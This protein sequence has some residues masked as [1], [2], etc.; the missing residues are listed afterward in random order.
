MVLILKSSPCIA[1]GYVFLMLLDA[2]TQK[3]EGDKSNI[4]KMLGYLQFVIVTSCSHPILVCVGHVWK[5]LLWFP[6]KCQET[7]HQKFQVC[8]I[9]HFYLI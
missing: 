4:V 8:Y 3:L 7:Y 2:I 6:L 5:S 9:P 1:H